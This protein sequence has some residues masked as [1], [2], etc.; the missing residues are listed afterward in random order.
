MVQDSHLQFPLLTS[1]IPLRET[2]F[3]YKTSNMIT[4]LPVC[5]MVNFTEVTMREITTVSI[6]TNGAD[7]LHAGTLED[8]MTF[9]KTPGIKMELYESN[10]RN[11]P[12]LHRS[13]TSQGS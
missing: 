3:R 2:N 8:L 12:T 5:L 9:R 13:L 11:Y 6:L 4:L 7:S 10:S 1:R